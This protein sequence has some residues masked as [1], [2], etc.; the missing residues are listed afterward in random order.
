MA[1]KNARGQH[2][3]ILL[4]SKVVLNGNIKHNS[5]KNTLSGD[6]LQYKP[7][8]TPMLKVQNSSIF[9]ENFQSTFCLKKKKAKNGPTLCDIT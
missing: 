8:G 1:H 5:Q 6:K 7:T 9:G 3:K 4:I 2:L